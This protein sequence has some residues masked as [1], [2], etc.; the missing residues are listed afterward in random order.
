MKIHTAKTKVYK[1]HDGTLT[2]DESDPEAAH[3]FA[4]KGQAITSDKLDGIKNAAKFFDMGEGVPSQH[5]ERLLP[6]KS[7]DE[8]P[9]KLEDTPEPKAAKAPASKSLKPQADK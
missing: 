4:A 9:V 2:A 7:E 3:I 8:P 6:V 5:E 1:R